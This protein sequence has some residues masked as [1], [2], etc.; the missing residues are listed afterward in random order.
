M[1]NKIITM[2]ILGCCASRNIFNVKLGN[3]YKVSSYIFNNN[4]F[5]INQSVSN[6]YDIPDADI[7]KLPISELQH[8]HPRESIRSL[9]N[10]NA[11]ETLLEK[12]GEWILLDTHYSIHDA[13]KLKYPNGE[14]TILQSGYAKYM[15]ALIKNCS[16]LKDFSVERSAS[17]IVIDDYIDELCE[18][19]R[20]NWGRNIILL[21]T[22]PSFNR[23]TGPELNVN[24]YLSV[25]KNELRNYEYSQKI[26]SRLDCH[27]IEIPFTMARDAESSVHYTSEIQEYLKLKVDI[28]INYGNT[29]PRK[30]INAI[31]NLDA[32]YGQKI[33]KI[34]TQ[35]LDGSVSAG[36]MG[37]AYRDGKGVEKDLDKAAE[38]MR[39]AS[40]AGIGWAKNE[41]FDILWRIGTPESYREMISVATAFAEL[42]DGNAMGRIGRAYRD[43]KGV[44]KDLDKAAEWMRKA[45]DKAWL[46][47]VDLSDLLLK[48]PKKKDHEEAFKICSS[49]V[50]RN[51]AEAMGYLGRMYRDGKG[52]E[53]NL[54]NAAEWMRKAA[55][56]NVGW[57]KNELNDIHYK[58]FNIKKRRLVVFCAE[59][60]S[61]ISM[62]IIVR[63]IKHRDDYAILLTLPREDMPTL[64]TKLC[65]NK[66]FDHVIT[67]KD[68][69]ISKARS[70][71]EIKIKE[72]FDNILGPF[73][74]DLKDSVFYVSADQIDLFGAYLQINKEKFFLM[75]LN[76]NQFVS[77]WRGKALLDSGKISAE[78]HAYQSKK[79]I[80]SGKS[81]SVT[82]I[83]FPGTSI[84]PKR[85]VPDDG[86]VYNYIKDME[87]LS[88][89]DK[90]LIL[91][92]FSLDNP[93]GNNNIQLILLNRLTNVADNSIYSVLE[94]PYIYQTIMDY[95]GDR[96]LTTI[97]K[98]HP[99]DNINLSGMS[100]NVAMLNRFFPIELLHLYDGLRISRMIGLYTSASERI[101]DLVDDKLIL[102]QIYTRICPLIHSLESSL[103]VLSK[104]GYLAKTL[105]V[106]I[107]GD[108]DSEVEFFKKTAKLLH[109]DTCT[110]IKPLSSYDNDEDSII[111]VKNRPMICN[112][113][114]VQIIL[115]VDSFS[116][117]SFKTM[118][119]VNVELKGKNQWFLW[120]EEKT[121]NTIVS[122][123]ELDITECEKND[124]LEACGAEKKV[125]VK[126]KNHKVVVK[127]PNDK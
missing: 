20:E 62:M 100:N 57:A 43:G 119:D 41:L 40:N 99:N 109:L 58:I 80:I 115:S 7:I 60:H 126:H 3:E 84:F 116:F 32:E 35:Y 112:D 26:L 16:A 47:G 79:E 110:N 107:T 125:T 127:S 65:E 17:Q 83:Y 4:P 104:S 121:S 22:K 120:K 67:Y 49:L 28:I 21:N 46:W 78:F 124:Y 96:N 6:K 123:L 89:S 34:L 93:I 33:R 77:S 95:F 102:G 73:R 108:S 8:A 10:C 63:F 122:N 101:S 106:G 105:F 38:W 44:E 61:A 45:M 42:G 9:I 94:V 5:L 114:S 118:V 69:I 81:D 85:E 113:S 48:S 117:Q 90:K 53:M 24:E 23:V 51:S 71:F 92:A 54:D 66:I 68:N 91:S 88:K 82:P 18:F 97:I 19:L 30:Y 70:E 111:L 64:S 98:Q 103:Y 52:V 87:T 11:K 13:Y 72:Y 2:N 25:I 55:N 29:S 56:K 39:K 86:L 12:K 37:R 59:H 1:V 74:K 31:N 15:D 75:E 50:K 76:S 36:H 14:E 27:Y